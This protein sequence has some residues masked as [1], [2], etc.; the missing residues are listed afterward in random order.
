MW[1]VGREE[2]SPSIVEQEK[3]F[4]PNP[5]EFERRFGIRNSFK[6]TLLMA[7]TGRYQ[8]DL[9]AFDEYLHEQH[10]YREDEHGSCKDFV[11]A[12]FGDEAVEF[13]ERLI[14]HSV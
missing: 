3:R 13:L 14:C 12:R 8:F 6:D 7:A 5:K 10:G 11:K 9:I 1:R 2:M 4:G